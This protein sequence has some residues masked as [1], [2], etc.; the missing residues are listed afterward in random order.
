MRA[1]TVRQR[2]SVRHGAAPLSRLAGH[3]PRPA[4]RLC[5]G[6]VEDEGSSHAG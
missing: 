3:S 6:T 4:A 2:M 5:A 1:A